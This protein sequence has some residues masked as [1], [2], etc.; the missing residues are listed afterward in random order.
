MKELKQTNKAVTD[1]SYYARK[2]E[3][4][5]AEAFAAARNLEILEMKHKVARKEATEN[6]ELYSNLIQDYRLLEK[7]V[8]E[9]QTEKYVS[10]FVAAVSVIYAIYSHL[11]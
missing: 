7:Q 11:A 10:Y 6:A 5:E 8:Y 2:K 1:R 4:L 3:R 9:R